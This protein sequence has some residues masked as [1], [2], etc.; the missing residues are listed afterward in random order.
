[1]YSHLRLKTFRSAMDRRYQGGPVRLKWTRRTSVAQ[2][3]LSQVPGVSPV[4]MLLR[5]PAADLPG[6]PHSHRTRYHPP[7]R[8]LPLQRERVRV[9]A[10]RRPIRGVLVRPHPAEVDH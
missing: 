6:V 3:A 7:A 4:P 9:S 8:C 1:M 5:V 2:C 10:I